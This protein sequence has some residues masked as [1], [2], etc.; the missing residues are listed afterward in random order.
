MGMLPHFRGMEQF[1]ADIEEYCTATATT[2]QRLLRAS[3][4]AGWGQW[5]KWKDG[6]SS[7]TMIVADRVRAYMAKHSPANAEGAA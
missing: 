6:D 1:L 2:P 7:P 4:G 3:I 5:Q